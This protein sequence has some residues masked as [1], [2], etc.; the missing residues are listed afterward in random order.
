MPNE[1]RTAREGALRGARGAIGMEGQNVR[2]GT[3]GNR[4]E[5]TSRGSYINYYDD[6]GVSTTPENAQ[7]IRGQEKEFNTGVAEQ[8][9]KISAANSQLQGQYSQG[10]A[11][12]DVAKSGVP[13]S[14]AAIDTAWKQTKSTF[15][16]VRVVSGDK[17]EQ[18]Y[19]LPKESADNLV[20]S[21]G[22]FANYVD[23]GKYLNVEVQGKGGKVVGK[24][25][26][27]ALGQAEKDVYNNWYINSAGTMTKAVNQA[28][29]AFNT[30]KQQAYD[31]LDTQYAS[32]SGKI[33]EAQGVVD[34]AVNKRAAEWDQI[35]SDYTKKKATIAD[36]FSKMKVNEAK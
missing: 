12:I 30:Q 5:H 21:Q 22:L 34:S 13:T 26:H 9:G 28:N 15:V 32:E 33:G 11:Q 36:I 18:T 2:M 29:T 3:V 8:Q 14:K 4:D 19:Y 24:E 10:T 27:T 16:P 20:K 35:H 7:S 31:T 17:I 1:T 6:L 25:L 23:N